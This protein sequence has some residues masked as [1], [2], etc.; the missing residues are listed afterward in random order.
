MHHHE[1]PDEGAFL[2]RLIGVRSPKISQRRISESILGPLLLDWLDLP[3]RLGE[4]V[5]LK[6]FEV[7]WFKSKECPELLDLEVSKELT[8]SHEVIC[9]RM[10]DARNSISATFLV[11]QQLVNGVRR[12]VSRRRSERIHHPPFRRSASEERWTPLAGSVNLDP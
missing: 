2:T 8:H 4:E 11:S 6:Q 5:R 7:R 10:R 3:A 1:E 9:V 12:W